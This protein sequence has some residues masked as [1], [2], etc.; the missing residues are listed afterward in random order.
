MPRDAGMTPLKKFAA[1]DVTPRS[2][3][4]REQI[5]SKRR[6]EVREVPHLNDRCGAGWCDERWKV[7]R[8]EGGGGKSTRRPR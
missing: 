5:D 6:G 2:A 7:G 8:R 3:G 1:D 4:E